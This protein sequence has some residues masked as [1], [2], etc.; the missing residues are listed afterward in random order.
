MKESKYGSELKQVYYLWHL[1]ALGVL[2]VDNETENIQDTLWDQLAKEGD[3][4]PSTIVMIDVGCSFDH[5]NLRGRVDSEASID[6]TAGAQG[7]RLEKHVVGNKPKSN[8]ESLD[9]ELLQ[10][11]GLKP[12]DLTLFEEIVQYLQSA[13]GQTRT[14][15]DVEARFSS[16]GTSVAGL[17]VGGPEIEREKQQT[18]SPGVIPYF[19]VDPF[20]RLVSVRTGFENDPLQ[21]VA[22]LLYAWSQSPDVIVLPRGLPDPVES[23]VSFKDDF[24]AELESWSSHEAA[25]VLHRF[26]ALTATASVMDSQSPQSGPTQTRLWHVVRALIVAISKHIPIVCAAGNEGESQLLYPANLATRENGIISVGAVAGSGYR[27]AYAN[28]GDGLTLVAPSDDMTVFNRHQLRET[29]EIAAKHSYLQ[30]AGAQSVPFS[31]LGL[32]STD[33]GGAFGYD[34]GSDA[35]TKNPQSGFYTQFGGTS[36]AAALV[37]GV[38]SL[39]RRAERLNQTKKEPMDGCD[40]RALLT[41]TARSTLPGLGTPLPLRTDCMNSDTE[42]AESQKTFFGAGLIDARAA[43][44]AVLS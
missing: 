42:D 23:A 39:V 38:I 40:I 10:L 16:H 31:S 37:A 35:N 27:S 41:N 4:V 3:V 22:A 6:F 25:D 33:V 9:T 17:I 18:P 32:L 12:Q 30:P 36:G 28:Y 29:E 26:E 24:K 34:S 14:T 2:S 13:Q 5:P 43:V 8:F 1:A 7:Q 44:S 21:F 11:D 15:G 19:G 20:S